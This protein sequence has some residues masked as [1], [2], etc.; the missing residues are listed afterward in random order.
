MS[1]THRSAIKLEQ[2]VKASSP[3]L[4]T[5]WKKNLSLASEGSGK[6]SVSNRERRFS[7][8]RALWDS[9]F[10]FLLCVFFLLLASMS[11]LFF[12]SP[13]IM[14]ENN[15]WGTSL[16]WVG[17]YNW[18]LQVCEPRH[19]ELSKLPCIRERKR[20]GERKRVMSLYSRG[21]AF[22]FFC[23]KTGKT[24]FLLLLIVS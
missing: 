15:Q 6:D 11:F 16:L 20:E 24:F 18:C 1:M 4:S 12:F 3:A 21:G 9:S 14:G 7:L 13:T 22:Q 10:N 5:R 19:T 2:K 17:D 8:R 23:R